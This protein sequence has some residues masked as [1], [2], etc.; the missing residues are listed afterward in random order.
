ML[1]A[2][3]EGG[4]L[5]K[6]RCDAVKHGKITLEEATWSSALPLS[7]HKARVIG[8]TQAFTVQLRFYIKSTMLPKDHLSVICAVVPTIQAMRDLYFCVLE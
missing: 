8:V 5:T 1:D 3:C 7:L 6:L 4:Q 2:F